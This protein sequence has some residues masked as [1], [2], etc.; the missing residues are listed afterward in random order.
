MTKTR[1]KRAA[2][3]ASAEKAP[4][5]SPRPGETHGFTRPVERSYSA[6]FQAV[7]SATSIISWKDSCRS[8]AER[9]SPVKR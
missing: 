9:A 6:H 7:S 2:S 5:P 8:S 3:A 1:R 4:F